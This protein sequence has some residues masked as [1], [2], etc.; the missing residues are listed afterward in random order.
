MPELR[1]E[2]HIMAKHKT[3]SH[4][5]FTCY[6]QKGVLNCIVS[7]GTKDFTLSVSTDDVSYTT[8]VTGVLQD[9]R[10]VA[11]ENV[12]L[13]EFDMNVLATSVKIT[14]LTMLS[15]ATGLGLQYINFVADG[16]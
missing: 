15:G 3:G 10:N 12:P 2:T 1:S 11:C 8:V 7:R 9:A 5:T 4:S 6:I 13:E 16:M 14:L